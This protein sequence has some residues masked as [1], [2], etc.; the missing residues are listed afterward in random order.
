M[1]RKPR[2]AATWARGMSAAANLPRGKGAFRPAHAGRGFSEPRSGA[3]QRKPVSEAD[4]EHQLI[5]G[6][7]AAAAPAT[8]SAG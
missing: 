6:K 8:G 5:A 3:R 1:S 4:S 7:R 2:T